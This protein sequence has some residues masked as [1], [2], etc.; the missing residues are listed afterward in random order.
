M[1]FFLSL[2]IRTKLMTGFIF[3]VAIAA[4]IG[5]VGM[6]NIDAINAADTKL[7]E[8]ITI[9]VAQLIDIS[10]NFQ[11]VRVTTRDIIN[12]ADNKD[13][14]ESN[15]KLTEG[16]IKETAQINSSFKTTLLTQRG[17]EQFDAYI[18]AFSGYNDVVSKVVELVK[19]GKAKEANEYFFGEGTKYV[20]E[21]GECIDNLIKAKTDYAK[22]TADDNTALANQSNN[23][24]TGLIIAG[25]II[26]LILGL[27]ISQ[28]IASNLIKVVEVSQAIAEGDLTK[29][30]QVSTGDELKD[31]ADAFNNMSNNLRNVIAQVREASEQLAIASNEIS[32]NAQS[33]SQGAQNQ[34]ST[35]EEISASIA[36][37]TK[38]TNDVANSA[39]QTN[40]M[41]E[42]TRKEA[43]D[44]GMSVNNSIE[45][46]KLINRS[47][48]QI[49]EIISVISDIADQTNL[50]ALNAAIEAA[51]AG[52]HGMGFAVVAD[53]VRKLAE[54]SSTAA[55][56]ITSLIK[57]STTRVTDGSKLSE[58]AGEALKK[59]LS[60]VEKTAG[61]IEQISA[62]TEQQGATANEVAK[63]VENVAAIT[64]E[65]AGASE[66]MAASA[67]ELSASADSLKVI[68][69]QFNIGNIDKLKAQN[70]A[71]QQTTH[72][73]AAAEGGSHIVK[74]QVKPAKKAI[75]GGNKLTK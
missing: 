41:A 35:V 53:E 68:V 2:K 58:Q 75:G 70:A 20:G 49:S 64:E 3:V 9:P 48:E 6:R 27:W 43:G 60:S 25:V 31:L 23:L 33:V 46:M 63:A 34:A 18:K 44:G 13:K 4:I 19:Q 65:N 30:V 69:E 12:F 73:Q 50:L 16:L 15:L 62:A 37:L 42:E 14:F 28:I 56:E 57:E 74:A 51:R 1:N 7:Y 39:Q 66:E 17:R 22:Q 8:K 26:A 61:A 47:S 21:F 54:R 24:M 40:Q 29:N 59:I 32:S 72:P 55:K 36:E 5:Y 10:T 45:A 52:E 67:E 38:S 71:A 11:K